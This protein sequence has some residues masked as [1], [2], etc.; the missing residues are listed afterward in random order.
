MSFFT[1]V[2]NGCLTVVEWCGY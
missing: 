1:N 2:D